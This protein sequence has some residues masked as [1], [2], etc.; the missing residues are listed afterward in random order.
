MSLPVD[1]ANR[2]VGSFSLANST[3]WLP[4][5]QRKKKLVK[6]TES[7]TALCDLTKEIAH[8]STSGA[9]Y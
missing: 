6:M 4:T 9:R 2:T 5:I 8:N 1:G 7:R 3:V